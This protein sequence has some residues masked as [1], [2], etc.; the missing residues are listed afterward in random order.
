MAGGLIDKVDNQHLVLARSYG[1]QVRG[2]H[3]R[4]G[5]VDDRSRSEQ[6]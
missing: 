3:M 5:L 4:V 6:H 1:V 2:W